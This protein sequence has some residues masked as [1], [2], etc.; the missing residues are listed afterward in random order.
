MSTADGPRGTSPGALPLTLTEQHAA[1]NAILEGIRQSP[2]NCLPDTSDT[3]VLGV[4]LASYV[5]YLGSDILAVAEHALATS[6]MYG[7]AQQV[8]ALRESIER[9]E[10]A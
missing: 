7:R 3:A 1:M 4:L 5:N 9:G 10:S 2:R 6:G 8:K